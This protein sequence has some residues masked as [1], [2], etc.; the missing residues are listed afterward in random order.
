M[1]KDIFCTVSGL[2]G[3]AVTSAFGGWSTGLVTLLIFMTADYLTGMICAGVFRV[4][5]KSQHGGLESRAGWKGLCRKAVALLIVL[6]AYRLDLLTGTNYIHDAVIIGFCIN[7]LISITEN[8][9]LMG[10]PMP[11][12]VLRAID[13]LKGRDEDK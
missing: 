3:S 5:K 6:T 1:I 4:S 2:V 10:V 9:G 11:K 13:I 7:E 8:C 12:P